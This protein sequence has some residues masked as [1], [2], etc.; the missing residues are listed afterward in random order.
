MILDLNG[1]AATTGELMSEREAARALAGEASEEKGERTSLLLF[2]AGDGDPKAV[3]LALVSRLEDIDMAQIEHAAGRAVLQYRNRLMPLVTLDGMMPE[4]GT[5]AKQV[6]VFS[7][8]DRT[9]GLVV[10]EIIDIVEATLSVELSGSSPGCIGTAIVAERSTDL[11]DVGFYFS[12][13]FDGW[14]MSMRGSA[15]TA[16]R[17]VLVIDE[18]PF[19]RNL[20]APVLTTAGYRVSFAASAEEAVA[21]CGEGAEFDLILADVDTPDVARI[22]EAIQGSGSWSGTPVVGLTENVAD[23]AALGLGAGFRGCV[24]KGDRLQILS[25]LSTAID[26]E[27][28]AA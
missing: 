27:R 20:L 13:A 4:A 9:M 15:A 25:V 28:Q 10:D 7:D 17:R 11:I 14:S 1:I 26:S 22:S 19:F 2:R 5:G 23:P 18:S 24:A 21:L 12:R 6:H 3:P 8:R 16:K